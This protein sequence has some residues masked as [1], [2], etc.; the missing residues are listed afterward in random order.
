MEIKQAVAI[1]GRI[2]RFRQA[3]GL[4]QEDLAKELGVSPPT[5]SK[6]ESGER[7]IKATEIPTLY[8]VLGCTVHELFGE[9]E[10]PSVSR[11]SVH[12][13]GMEG[14]SV[15]DERELQQ[16]LDRLG[17]QT[18]NLL[19]LEDFLSVTP[20]KRFP[21]SFDPPAGRH[22]ER[23]VEAGERAWLLRTQLNLGDDA[24]PLLEHVLEDRSVIVTRL[25]LPQ[26]FSGLCVLYGERPVIVLNA[27]EPRHRQSFSLAHELC[28]AMLDD[29][30]S[31][32]VTRRQDLDAWA[33]RRP[34][35]KEHRA[36]LFAGK[37]L[38][39]FETAKSFARKN[40][41]DLHSPSASDIMR[42]AYH[43]GMSGEA[44]LNT[45]RN[46]GSIDTAKQRELEASVGPLP[47]D[48]IPRPHPLD[49][50]C[51]ETAT[52]IESIPRLVRLA[53]I[54]FFDE[55]INESA[56]VELLDIER[57]RAV[58][59]LREYKNQCIINS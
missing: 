11:G 59:L 47:Q 12:L 24:I 51:E 15:E 7:Q 39:P 50:W 48:A 22:E 45:L 42:L 20:M 37:F 38:M 28:H 35:R 23:N 43:F 5:V 4:R 29:L 30:S 40:A 13:R 10:L 33:S 17:R 41:F 54:A 14:I 18:K 1:G 6:I 52:E 57:T 34:N 16:V 32:I 3:R 44:V 26:A 56:L 8:H 31:A 21:R 2:R 46:Y 36:N 49:E 25:R 55:S 27:H 19:S 58:A 53:F 9:E